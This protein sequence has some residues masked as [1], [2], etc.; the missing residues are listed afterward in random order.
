M[1]LRASLAYL[2]T[3][4]RLFHTLPAVSQELSST[5]STLPW[6]L[7]CLIK[8]SPHHMLRMCAPMNI[9]VHSRGHIYSIDFSLHTLGASTKPE[10][11]ISSTGTS[12]NTMKRNMKRESTDSGIFHQYLPLP[13]CLS[14]SLSLLMSLFSCPSSVFKEHITLAKTA[15]HHSERD[16]Q[17]K[18]DC[19]V[20]NMAAL[21]LSL[22]SLSSLSLCLTYITDFPPAQ[23]LWDQW[24]WWHGTRP[25]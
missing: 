18:R 23:C 10:G 2:V 20:R 4:C 9:S 11:K 7:G 3:R 16:R 12:R 22:H 25:R 21:L 24:P 19:S 15:G 8:G 6:R 13:L 1:L 5:P 14:L 17:R